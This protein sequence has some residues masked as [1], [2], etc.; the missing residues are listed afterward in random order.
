MFQ[1]HFLIQRRSD[2]RWLFSPWDL[3]MDFGGWQGPESSI[4]M[5][6]EGDPSNRLGWWNRWKDAFLQVYRDE[7]VARLREY[8]DD[9]LSPAQIEQ[10]VDEVAAQWV[11]AEIDAAP[12][13]FDCSFPDAADAFKA[14]AWT[15]HDVVEAATTP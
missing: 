15:R 5:G 10:R 14:F 2:G 1:N 9:I 4:F 3:D 7:Y 12:A 13:G 11:Q 8:N 6:E